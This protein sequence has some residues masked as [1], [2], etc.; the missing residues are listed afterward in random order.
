MGKAEGTVPSRNLCP[1]VCS[2]GKVSGTLGPVVCKDAVTVGRGHC[3]GEA[4]TAMCDSAS[5]PVAPGRQPGER[6]DTLA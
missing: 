3:H 2:W 4:S 6:V 1:L 5:Q